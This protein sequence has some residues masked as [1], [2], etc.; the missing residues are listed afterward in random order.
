MGVL[1]LLQLL[2]IR[3]AFVVLY[4]VVEE[5]GGFVGDYGSEFGNEDSL[6]EA[7]C[8]CVYVC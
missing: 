6:G 8:V 1:A 5:D 3:A 7:E 4:R 2:N